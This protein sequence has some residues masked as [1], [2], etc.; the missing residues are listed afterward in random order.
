MSLVEILEAIADFNGQITI[1]QLIG[2]GLDLDY[3]EDMSC[4]EIHDALSDCFEQE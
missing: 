2:S 3:F 4:E 1:N